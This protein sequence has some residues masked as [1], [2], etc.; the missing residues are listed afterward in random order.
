MLERDAPY[1]Q[2]IEHYRRRIAAGQLRDGDIICRASSSSAHDLFA[3]RLAFP[4]GR[5]QSRGVNVAEPGD[6]LRVFEPAAVPG[7]SVRAERPPRSSSSS[8]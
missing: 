4:A 6:V 1:V 7:T 2:I 3:R 5:L 8:S